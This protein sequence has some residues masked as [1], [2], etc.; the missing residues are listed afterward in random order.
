MSNCKFIFLGAGR[1]TKG[2]K[3]TALMDV[4]EGKRVLDWLFQA[5]PDSVSDLE[6]V[7]GYNINDIA[8]QFRAI[9]FTENPDWAG[10]GAAGS[11]FCAELPNN[12]SLMVSYSDILYRPEV[13]DKLINGEGQIRVAIDSKWKERYSGRKKEELQSCEKVHLAGNS[14]TRLG[15]D[16][17]PELAE[18]EFVGLV[19]LVNP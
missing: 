1:P 10:T 11:L 4:L 5:I 15:S 3:P 9:K 6:F 13:I 19:F 7:G 8:S 12:G 14:I 18:A 16:L 2:S 17:D